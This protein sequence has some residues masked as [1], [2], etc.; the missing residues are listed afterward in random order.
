VEP[1]WFQ[2]A[3]SVK[4]LRANPE[5]EPTREGLRAS[6][7]QRLLPVDES[8]GSAVATRPKAQAGCEKVNSPKATAQ[9]PCCPAGIAGNFCL[10]QPAV[11][12]RFAFSFGYSANKTPKD[13]FVQTTTSPLSITA[14]VFLVAIIPTATAWH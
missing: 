3:Q 4:V 5:F 9:C 13:R 6:N 11:R 1:L 8:E 10:A 2:L 12:S 14:N 7:F